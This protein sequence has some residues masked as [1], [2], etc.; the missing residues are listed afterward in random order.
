MKILMITPD[1]QMIDRRILQE[2]RSLIGVG[3]EVVLLAGFECGE[4]SSYEQDG[5]TIHRFRYDWDDE[6]LKQVRSRLAAM[7]WLHGFVNRLWM[8]LLRRFFRLTSFER[9][10]VEAARRHR[11]DLVHVHDLPLLRCGEVV[12]REWG[13][14]LVFD[15]HEIYHAQEVLAPVLRRRLLRDERELLPKCSAV[16]TVNE[17]LAAVFHALHGVPMPTVL[18]NSAPVPPRDFLDANRDRLRERVGGDGPIVLFQGWISAER[19]IE[20]LVAAMAHVGADARL[21]IIGYGDHEPRLR[22]I[23]RERGLEERVVFLGR[24]E[25]DEILAYTA[26]ADLGVIPYLPIDL[27]HR[28]CSPNKFFEFVLSGVP[29]LAHDLPFFAA[30]RGRFGVVE[31]T[32]V[33]DP[34]ATGATIERL[35]RDGRLPAM[36]ERCFAARD[37]L[38]WHNDA[39]R[40]LQV[41]AGLETLSRDGGPA[42]VAA[43]AE[44]FD[45]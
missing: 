38:G 11:A 8:A 15:A 4:D 23:A 29:V 5:I 14:P 32:D 20:T 28:Y 9:F 13:V 7:P 3:H 6:R 34:A 45:A 37:R 21:A 40:L 43:R 12:A 44:R 19:N 27:N 41:Y 22:E 16:I 2:A 42:A 36:R 18:Y 31:C 1:C 35:L 17:F 24:V 39:D 10:V 30:M 25:P 33:S 26:G